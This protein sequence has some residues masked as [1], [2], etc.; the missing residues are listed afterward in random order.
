MIIRIARHYARDIVIA[1]VLAVIAA[2]LID[3]YEKWTRLQAILNNRRAVAMLIARDQSGRVVAQGTGFFINRKGILATAYHVVKGA[4]GVQ[5]HLSS[6]A[7]YNLKSFRAA[8]EEADIAILQFDATETPSVS[9]L[10]NSDKLQVGEEV[11]AIGTP[12]G[13]RGTVST[14]NIS[15]PAQQITGRSFIQF[16]APISPGSSGGGLFNL[17]GEVVGITA[18][19]R[20]AQ[21]REPAKLRT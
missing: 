4:V 13:L 17:D 16:T 21:G 20:S 19:L 2:V 1:L 12:V 8:D 18:A 10:G 5:A 11:Y 14:G 9:G 15:N 3:R 6:G 7:F